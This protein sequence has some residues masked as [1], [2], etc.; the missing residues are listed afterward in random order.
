VLA[1]AA[2][3]LAMHRIK[4][5]NSLPESPL[6]AKVDADLLKQA[7]LNV[8]LNGAQAM[9]EGGR[10]EVTL[11]ETPREAVL[12]IAD[13]GPGI[14]EEIREKI[15]NLYFTTKSGGSGIGLAMSYR[16]LQMHHGSIDVESK[17]GRG[18]VFFLRIPLAAADRGHR[19]MK[20]TNSAG[21]TR[22]RR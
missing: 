20:A 22:V 19:R 1:L 17:E 3:E 13:Q 7:A 21:E 9:P 14:P 12:R 5:V 15:F 11:E 4:L 6:V 2:D 8:I 16:I 10:L 18:A